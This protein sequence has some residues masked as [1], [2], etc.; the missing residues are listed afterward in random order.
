LG[1]VLGNDAAPGFDFYYDSRCDY[2]IR[3]V[4]SNILAVE[5]DFEWNL[6]LYCETGASTFD[7]SRSA[8]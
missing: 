5:H 4:V 6:P 3:P 1:D 2:E 8:A 7:D